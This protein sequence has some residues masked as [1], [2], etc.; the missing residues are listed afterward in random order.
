MES[1]VLTAMA[2]S[3]KQLIQ[4]GDHKQLRPKVNNYA[5]TVEKGDGF[6]LNRS[7][8]ERMI[9]QGAPHTTLTKQH[10]MVPEISAFPRHLTYPDP[11]DSPR[12]SGRPAILGLQDRVV[13]L[14]HGKLEDT[15]KK[16][17]DRRDPSTK[18]SK[19]NLFEAEMVLRCVKYFGQQ[20]YSSEKMVILT[21][22]LGQ[23]R[24]LQDILQK[25][26]HDPELSELDKFDL[27]RAGLLTH[28]AAKVDRKPLRI[29]TIGMSPAPQI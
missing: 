29:S 6:D 3:V 25:N 2:P 15:D 22:Y 16:I 23:L 5:M 7:L 19:K 13:F 26:Q 17:R 28:A 8:F 18:A 20:G 9:L 1:H 21:P 12:T 14:N 24:I 11:L 4:I 27:I 10:R